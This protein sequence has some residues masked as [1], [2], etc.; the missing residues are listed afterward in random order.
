MTARDPETAVAG[1]RRGDTHLDAR[2]LRAFLDGE[3]G[4]V[5]RVERWAWEIVH[6]R[7][8]SIPLSDRADL[9]QDAVADVWRA[10]SRAGFEL[11]ESLRALARRVASA[12]CIDWM[13]KRRP[14][15][16]LSEDWADPAPS[17]YEALLAKD[18]R[19]RVRWAL[20]ALD[21]RCR[22]IIR[23][24]FFE[25]LPYAVIAERRSRSESTMRVHMFHCM[26]R[27]RE[28]WERW[29]R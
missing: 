9:V 16:S 2:L 17:P 20:M 1:D 24:H 14:S 28:L 3:P 18:Q 12:R 6:F 23:E 25:D 27:I 19:A 22:E 4:A 26:K 11:R 5:R 7:W 21:E 13:R 10:A 15:A 8:G 29:A